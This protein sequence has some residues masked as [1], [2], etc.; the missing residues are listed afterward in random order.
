[1]PDDS[2]VNSIH[3]ELHIVSSCPLSG[4]LSSLGR[5]SSDL[6]CAPEI[7]L[8]P[9]VVI[10]VFADPRTDAVESRKPR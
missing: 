3:T 2:E 6:H 7:D 1:M 5:D 4:V 8:D 9:L 10:V